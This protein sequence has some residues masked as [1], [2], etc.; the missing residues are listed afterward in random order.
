MEDFV[1]CSSRV[2]RETAHARL[3]LARVG[4]GDGGGLIF[5]V[6]PTTAWTAAPACPLTC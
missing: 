4:Y 2:R 3:S 1:R 6:P 5:I